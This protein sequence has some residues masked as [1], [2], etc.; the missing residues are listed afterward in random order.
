MDWYNLR[1]P[2]LRNKAVPETGTGSHYTQ[3]VEATDSPS[4]NSTTHA[5]WAKT[6]RRGIDP[7]FKSHEA[8][9][10][11]PPTITNS[12]LVPPHRIQLKKNNSG[13]RFIE[14][15]RESARLSRQESVSQMQSLS[16]SH[17]DPFPPQAWV[18]D[19]LPIPLPRLSEWIHAGDLKGIDIHK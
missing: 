16:H 15:F 3:D 14:R 1:N 2:S 19:D 8:S 6:I 18:Q 10:A 13:S 4:Y 7:P 11:S 9:A 12:F 17:T 5:P